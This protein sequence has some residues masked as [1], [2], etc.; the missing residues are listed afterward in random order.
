MRKMPL[1][2]FTQ[3][4]LR[5]R[6]LVFCIILD[7]TMSEKRKEITK[8]P[9]KALNIFNRLHEMK[10]Y[11]EIKFSFYKKQGKSLLYLLVKNGHQC[12]R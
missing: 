7:L 3:K 2:C 4:L 9:L 10:K 8:K 1:E 6:P 12:I 11:R 5:V